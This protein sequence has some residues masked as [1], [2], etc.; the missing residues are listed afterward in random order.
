MLGVY[1]QGGVDIQE[2]WHG[3]GLDD[4]VDRRGKPA[5]HADHLIALLDGS[6]SQLGGGQCHK[7]Y[8][9]GRAATV[10]SPDSLAADPAGERVLELA[11]EGTGGQPA[12]VHGLVHQL[13]LPLSDHLTGGWDEGVTGCEG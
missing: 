1:V 11:V 12:L 8:K 5:G 9:V 13:L 7:G 4:G 2:H 6:V 10:D 3:T